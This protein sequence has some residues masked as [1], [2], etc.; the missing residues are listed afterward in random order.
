MKLPF[1]LVVV[2]FCASSAL[3]HLKRKGSATSSSCGRVRHS[4]EVNFLR[5]SQMPGVSA[6]GMPSSHERT[7][8]AYSR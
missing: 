4:C 8:G 6:R 5:S 3:L 7:A 2:L 1:A